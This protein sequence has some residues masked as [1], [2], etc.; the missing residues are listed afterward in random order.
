MSAEMTSA[1]TTPQLDIRNGK[2][3]IHLN[4]PAQ[5]NRLEPVD[6]KE[7][8]RMFDELGR[9]PAVR[10]LIITAGG[11]SFSAG[12]HLGALADDPE[13]AKD[14]DPDAFEKMV[15]ALETMPTPTIA[16]LNGGTYGGATDLALACDFRIGVEGMRMF[17]PAAR[18]GIVYYETGLRRYV[19]RLGLN[20]AKRLFLTAETVEADELLTMG[21]LTELVAA[22]ELEA[23]TDA[24]ASQIAA[25]APIAVAGL[26]QGL[27]EI[28]CGT[29]DFNIHQERRRKS[30]ESEDHKEAIAAWSEKRRPVFKGR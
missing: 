20:A 25:N 17:M 16:A 3:T 27:T 12:F 19:T 29:F 30:A 5:H 23:H 15:T 1:A 7:L 2:A 28:A 21:F 18:L 10:V 14:Y 6:L 22:D 13:A 11:K 24:L 8:T 9:D 4:R 26:K